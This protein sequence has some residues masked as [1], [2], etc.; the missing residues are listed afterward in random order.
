MRT[1]RPAEVRQTSD[2]KQVGDARRRAERRE[3]RRLDFYRQVMSTVAGRAVLWD[4]ISEAGVFETP[5]CN[6][7]MEV[8]RNIGRQDFGRKMLAELVALDEQLYLL[9]ETEART[10]DRHDAQETEAAHIAPA[11]QQG[12]VS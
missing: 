8:N 2:P 3:A 1:P 6:F 10:R 12:D 4:L 7:Q 5:W 11:T 9:M